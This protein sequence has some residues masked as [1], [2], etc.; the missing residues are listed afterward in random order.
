MRTPFKMKYSP[1]KGK[2]GDFFKN[3]TKKATPETK[4]K[5]A[6]A[7]TTRKAGESQY[8]ADVRTKRATSRAN[9]KVDKGEL[10]K[11]IVKSKV[12]TVANKPKN[13]TKVGSFSTKQKLEGKLVVNNKLNTAKVSDKAKKSISVKAAKPN[14]NKGLKGKTGV[15][16]R[17]YYDKHKLEYDK[18]ISFGPN[19]K[20]K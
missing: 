2:L 12:S 13:K 10:T 8:Q 5:R 15:E 16:R 3:I 9:K 4:A 11:N 17:K 14:H 1:V 18:T 19:F 20:K 7:K 6:K